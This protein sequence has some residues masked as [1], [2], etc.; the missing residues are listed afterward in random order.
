VNHIKWRKFISCNMMISTKIGERGR[1][2][3][4]FWLVPTD[5]NCPGE[6]A[7]KQVAVVVV[8]VC[9]YRISAL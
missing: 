5:P 6:R 3:F 7:T 2:C 1:E 8:H 9:G 4:F